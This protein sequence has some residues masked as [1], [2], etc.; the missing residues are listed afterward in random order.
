MSYF[1]PP[2]PEDADPPPPPLSPPPHA[3]TANAASASTAAASRR[4]RV[5][6]DVD[7]CVPPP[8]DAMYLALVL[9]PPAQLIEVDRADENGADGDLLPERLDADDHEAVGQHGGD[10]HPEHG[11]EDGADPAEQAGAPDHHGGDRV[12]VVGVVA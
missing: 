4:S 10:E 3:A 9:R 7:M 1:V 6:R 12:E 5:R 11:P 8:V 2:P